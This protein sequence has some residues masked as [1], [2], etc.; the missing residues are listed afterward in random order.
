MFIRTPTQLQTT[1]LYESRV[2]CGAN[3]RRL[4]AAVALDAWHGLRTLAVAVKVR[5][6]RGPFLSQ[7]ARRNV[8]AA[9]IDRIALAFTLFIVLTS[10]PFDTPRS[11]GAIQMVAGLNPILQDFGARSLHPP[12]LYAWAM[13]GFSIAFC[14]CSGG[15]SSSEAAAR[16][17]PGRDGSRPW[18][19]WL[20]WAC[21]SR[22]GSRWGPGGPITSW[23]G[24][25]GGSG[26]RSRTRQLHALAGGYRAHPLPGRF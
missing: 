16:R 9:A 10:N 5:E 4:D 25:A 20:A 22:S 13:S 2:P 12:F 11:H 23:A 14:L 7:S 8:L 17:R 3:A 19:N 1:D 18:T 6:L 15:S 26:T 24:V 21:R